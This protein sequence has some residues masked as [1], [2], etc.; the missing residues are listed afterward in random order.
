[1]R[2]ITTITLTIVSL[3]LT[4]TSLAQ[5][6]KTSFKDNTSDYVVSVEQDGTGDALDLQIPQRANLLIKGSMAGVETLFQVDGFGNAKLTGGLTAGQSVT[7]GSVNSNSSYQ[8]G[9][10]VVLS[11]QS[12]TD[13]NTFLGIGAGGGNVAG[14]GTNNVYVGAE[15]GK[16][17][18]TGQSN[19]FIGGS[20]GFVA[21]AKSTGSNNL[22]LGAFS[23]A[24]NVTG[25]NDIYIGSVGCTPSGGGR[26][27]NESNTI[28]IGGGDPAQTAAY[29]LGISGSTS[30]SG[31]E[32][33]INSDGKLGT[34]TSS[35][36]FKEQVHDMGGSTDALMKLRPVTFFYKPEYDD[37][38]RTLQYG[39]IAEEVAKVYPELVEFDNDGQPYS[40]RYHFITTMLLNEAQKQ[41]RRTEAQATVIA[42]QE[43]KID[44]QQREIQGMQQRLSRLEALLG[45]RVNTAEVKEPHLTRGGETQ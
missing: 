29:I 19:T 39:L 25:S 22:F 10:K 31:A 12:P 2:R 5:D 4:L 16:G 14:K 28:R 26:T 15:A 1:M 17:N 30:A 8:V 11:I 24:A 43:Q 38:D 34:K 41:Y 33:F 27:C 21:V 32:V 20:A 40:V 3:S 44:S 36:R 18:T 9:G 45:T 35:L 42:A 37:G 23:G 13:D 7:A 6:K